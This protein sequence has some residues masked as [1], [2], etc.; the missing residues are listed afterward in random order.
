MN[1]S[2]KEIIESHRPELFV[3]C[4]TLSSLVNS[5][6]QKQSNLPITKYEHWLFN[7][8]INQKLISKRKSFVNVG[9]RWEDSFIIR[10]FI[11]TLPTLYYCFWKGDTSNQECQWDET[12]CELLEIDSVN[13]RFEWVYFK[14]KLD[15]WY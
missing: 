13:T 2:I 4:R 1:S 10:V 8:I 12:S 15:S 9:L 11:I 14:L 5:P 6:N 3:T 7:Q